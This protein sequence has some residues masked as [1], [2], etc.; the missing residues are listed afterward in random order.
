MKTYLKQNNIRISD[1]SRQTGVPYTTVNEIING[2]IDIDKVRIKTGLMIADACNMDFMTF[3]NTCKRSNSLP[4]I[5]NGRIIK[6][7]KAYYLKCT[8]P[9]FD[10]EIY[11]CRINP[12]N[13]HFVKDMAEWTINSLISEAEQL[14]NTKEVEAWTND[15]I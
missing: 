6:K 7:N 2:K 11:L 4:S 15:T 3:Y 1:I 14:K 12:V 5:P 10:S 8:L 9:G 13:T